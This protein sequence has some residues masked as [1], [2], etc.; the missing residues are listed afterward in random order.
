M[1]SQSVQEFQD[2]MP[3]LARVAAEVVLP[4][5]R[6]ALPV[7]DKGGLRF[8]PVTEADRDAERALRAAILERY[9]DHSILGEEFGEHLGTSPYRWVIDPIDGT[10]AFISG[11]PTWGTLIA[12]CEH[13][14]PVLGMMSQP[15]VGEIFLGGGEASWL[16]RAGTRSRLQVRTGVALAQASVFATTPEMFSATELAAF[17][18]VSQAARLTRFGIDCYAYC[19]LAA[20]HVDLVIEAGLGFYDIAPLMPIVEAAGGVVTDWRGAPVRGGGRVIAAASPT[21]HAQALALLNAGLD[22]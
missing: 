5:F 22:D 11:A 17:E 12:L 21:L 10:R 19:L 13:N 8:D 16:L 9:P 15:Y 20:G 18:R 7:T 2:F 14:V 1:D 3:E 6:Q 4:R